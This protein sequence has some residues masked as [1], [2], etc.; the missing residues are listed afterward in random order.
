MDKVNDLLYIG[1]VDDYSDKAKFEREE[2]KAFVNV[3]GR[4][5]Q[6]RV[7]YEL[8]VNHDYTH[9]PLDDG[10]NPFRIFNRAVDAVREHLSD[11][12]KVFVN[13]AMGVS[14]SVAVSATALAVD[15]D[16]SFEEALKEIEDARPIANPKQELRGYGRKYIEKHKD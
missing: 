2:I 16:L 3:S 7:H 4:S 14:R 15:K 8:A 9:I 11:E 6:S 12:R 1:D 5:F 10:V 13:C